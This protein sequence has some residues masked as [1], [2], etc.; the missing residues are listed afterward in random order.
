MAQKYDCV[1]MDNEMPYGR[2]PKGYPVIVDFFYHEEIRGSDNKG[3]GG[4]I[5]SGSVQSAVSKYS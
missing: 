4:F 5:F 2:V 1:F 3:I